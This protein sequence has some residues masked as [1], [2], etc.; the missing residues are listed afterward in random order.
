MSKV[1]LISV[2][3]EFA[4]KIFD[5]SKQIE[6]RKCAPNISTGDMVI[7]YSTVPEKAVV[8][9]CVVKAVITKSPA[10]LWRKHST[11]LGID[12]KRYLEYFKDREKAI[13][14]V[15]S[16]TQRL[17]SKIKLAEIKRSFPNFSPPQTF[18][19]FSRKTVDL[20]Y[21]SITRTTR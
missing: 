8:G 14:I 10:E 21:K 15:L 1:L 12:R 16:S 13:G 9:T 17:K 11:K 5:G 4:E 20:A 7:V 2:K 6:L 3:P 19:Y 18:K